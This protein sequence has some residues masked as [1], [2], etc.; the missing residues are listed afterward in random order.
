MYKEIIELKNRLDESKI[1]YEMMKLYDGYQIAYPNIESFI[2]SVVQHRGSC[3]SSLELLEI[4]GLLTDEEAEEDTFVGYLT[5]KEVFE[6]ICN[7]YKNKNET[8]KKLKNETE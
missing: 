3:G 8:K 6:R 2:C 1:P 7:H 4:M 5:A